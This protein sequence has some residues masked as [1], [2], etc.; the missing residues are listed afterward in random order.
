MNT[1]LVREATPQQ[2][3]AALLALSNSLGKSTEEVQQILATTSKIIELTKAEYE[4]IQQAGKWEKDAIYLVTDQSIT[5]VVVDQHYS[6][7]SSNAQSG[8]AVAEAIADRVT[9]SQLSG[10]LANYTKQFIDL[11][12]NPI[13]IGKINDTIVYKVALA[14]TPDKASYTT[15]HTYQIPFNCNRVLDVTGMI[16]GETYECSVHI[17]TWGGGTSNPWFSAVLYNHNSKQLQLNCGSAVVPYY[18]GTL[19]VTYY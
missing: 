18:G 17:A 19:W 2:I 6:A 13:P 12:N 9:Q 14:M 8:T 16:I 7:T 10:A 15:N 11:Y 5:G 4:P 3:N 1:L